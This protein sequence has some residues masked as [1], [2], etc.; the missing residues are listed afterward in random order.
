MNDTTIALRALMNLILR[1]LDLRHKSVSYEY[2][3]IFNEVTAVSGKYKIHAGFG[4]HL[5]RIAE[6]TV[7]TDKKVFKT[8]RNVP[9]HYALD[10]VALKAQMME[11]D[12]DNYV[13]QR[14]M[15]S[16]L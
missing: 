12:I 13:T 9:F 14:E 7:S 8:L 1:D 10:N 16:M 15:E 4:E 3:E 5:D 2:N 11:Y 6:L